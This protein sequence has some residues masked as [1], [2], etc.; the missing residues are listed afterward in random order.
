MAALLEIDKLFKMK[1]GSVG[2]PDFYLGA[3]L[4][5]TKL[6]KWRQSLGHDLQKVYALGSREC[7]DLT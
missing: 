6:R 1:D 3:K 2:D 4:R 7:E 5:K